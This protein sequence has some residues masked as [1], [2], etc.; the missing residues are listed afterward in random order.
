MG[1]FS[2]SDTLSRDWRGA[3]LWWG[4]LMLTFIGISTAFIWKYAAVRQTAGGLPIL[5]D[6]QDFSLT[7]QNGHEVTRQ[8]L[9]GNAWV[10]DLIYTEC[11]SQCPLMTQKMA[12]IQALLP[13]ESNVQLL[14]ISVDPEHD[15]P[16]VL[17]DYAKHYGVDSA[18]WRFVTGSPNAIHALARDFK[19]APKYSTHDSFVLNHSSR[20]ILVDSCSHI[21]GTYDGTDEASVQQLVKDISTLAAKDV[22]P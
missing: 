15:S 22:I 2:L 7:D 21:R 10:A 6:V 13:R 4:L 19:L 8:M 11:R 1:T 17:S 12:K 9:E 20:L 16:A 18:H 14:S 3:H 5:G